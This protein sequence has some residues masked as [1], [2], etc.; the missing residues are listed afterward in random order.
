[1]S[2]NAINYAISSGDGAKKAFLHLLEEEKAWQDNYEIQS[3]F[4][5]CKRYKIVST[6][7]FSSKEDAL[8]F[9]NSNAPF[10]MRANSAGCVIINLNQNIQYLFFTQENT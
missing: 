8:T 9:I 2:T 10:K 5:N 1:M 4:S 3:A 7:H 6:D